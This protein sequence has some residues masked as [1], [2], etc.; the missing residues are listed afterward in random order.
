MA[1]GRKTSLVIVLSPQERETLERWQRSTTL[2]V[3]L[4]RRGR[5]ILLLAERYSQSQ[6]A[7]WVGVQRGVVR[8]WA[9]RFLAHRLDGLAD[10][11]G[12]GAKGAFPPGGGDPR[13]APGLRTPRY[14]GPQSLPMGLPRIGTS[15]HGRGH[16][17]GDLCL[18]RAAD[19]GG[20]SAEALAPSSLA[21]S[22]A[23]PGCQLLCHG[24]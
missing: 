2:A 9:K 24:R 14:P 17:G 1:R 23:P 8:K 6:V 4:A 3:G 22:Q 11:P 16:R 10:T 13:G 15:A 19:S 18:D 21:P 20:P 12:R 5:M 7:Q